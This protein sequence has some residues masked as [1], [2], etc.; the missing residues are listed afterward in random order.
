MAKSEIKNSYTL[1]QMAGLAIAQVNSRWHDSTEM[2]LKLLS[3]WMAL[4]S[5]S[6]GVV[7]FLFS[8]NCRGQDTL[9]REIQ[10]NY[11]PGIILKWFSSKS[12]SFNNE[13]HIGLNNKISF[14]YNL[15]LNNFSY[16]YVGLI[17]SSENIYFHGT[18]IFIE[19]K[20]YNSSLQ[21]YKSSFIEIPIG[22]KIK[23]NKKIDKFTFLTGELSGSVYSNEKYLFYENYPSFTPPYSN[24]Y[25]VMTY[26]KNYF[27][28]TRLIISLKF[29]RETPIGR[30]FTLTR[31][32]DI[33]M[34]SLIITPKTSL[35]LTNFRL[36]GI[37]GIG[38]H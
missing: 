17:Y 16:Y 12:N 13:I 2:L 36:N 15:F 6:A 20:Y 8:F 37:I 19:E 32:A 7:I 22:I 30:R 29:E 28:L 9:K 35:G 14:N 5:I 21:N 31:G 24:S 1:T 34:P 18:I 33:S 38:Y 26:N 27:G 23:L 11:S 3:N 25:S 4:K 10:F